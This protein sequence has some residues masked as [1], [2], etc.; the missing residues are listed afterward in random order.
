MRWQGKSKRMF[1]GGRLI[2]SRGK[3]KYELG[4]EPTNTHLSPERRKRVR[5]MG[6]NLKVVL[7][8]GQVAS[9]SDEAGN[10]R[11]V[12]LENVIE[13]PANEHY[14]RRNIITKGCT[15]LTEIGKARVVSRPGQSGTI[16]AVLLKD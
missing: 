4:R 2:R 15:V 1:T 6:G 7:L 12:K 3:K 13:N 8:R 16:N 14:V 9:V 10:T 5:G 11:K